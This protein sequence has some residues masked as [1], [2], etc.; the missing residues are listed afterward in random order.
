MS[1]KNKLGRMKNHLIREDG[2][3]EPRNSL[4]Q[5]NFGSDLLF[6]DQWDMAGVD[7]YHSEE[8][9]CLIREVR[10]PLDYRHGKYA[11][12]DLHT[13]LS[14]WQCYAGSHPLSSK[15]YSASDLFFFDT[16]TTGLG[17]GAGNVIFLLGYARFEE[18]EVII[19]Q[20]FLPEP[21]LEVPL[22]K[23]FLERVDYTTLVTYNGKAFDWP[24]VK[25]RHLLVRENVPMLPS[26]GHF[27]LY[28]AA[29]RMWKHQLERVKLTA[30]EEDILG[31]K[32]Q[33]D[34]P[35]HLAPMI[36]FDYVERKNPEAVIKVMEHNEMDILSLI[37]LYTHLSMQIQGLDPSQT[38]IEKRETGK[39][40]DYIGET[41]AAAAFFKEAVKLD[42][43]QAM[44]NMAIYHKREKNM[45]AAWG[46]F[47]E[48]VNEGEPA[49]GKRAAIELAKMAEHQNKDYGLALSYTE[50][51]IQLH[52]KD[53]TKKYNKPDSFKKEALKRLDRLFR[54]LERKQ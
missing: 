42:D 9:Y 40:F 54:K 10:Y 47:K 50:R 6:K 49:V 39:W 38:A 45:E 32:R 2:N 16:E 7:P 11:L 5:K 18:D 33:A 19:R 35:G 23:S 3:K 22:Y 28:H 51:A 34:V 21:G 30:V 26:F 31:I 37:T 1:L 12:R 13:A 36:Y 17:G 15:G 52:H 29:R 20:H 46:L 53:S 44:Y 25:S 8:G 4:G 48:A 14:A 41:E 27:D 24:Q 43:P